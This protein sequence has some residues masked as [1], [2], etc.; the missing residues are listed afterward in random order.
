MWDFF[1]PLFLSKS[2]TS[3]EPAATWGIFWNLCISSVTFLPPE[4]QLTLCFHSFIAQPGTCPSRFHHGHPPSL[5]PPPSNRHGTWVSL[6]TLEGA[7]TGD[8]HVKHHCSPLVHI[9]KP[10]CSDWNYLHL[11]CLS[12]PTV[13]QQQQVWRI[14]WGLMTQKIKEINPKTSYDVVA[15]VQL[16][17]RPLYC[18]KSLY[19]HHHVYTVDFRN[20]SS[21]YHSAIPSE[22][23]TKDSLCN[24]HGNSRVCFPTLLTSANALLSHVFGKNL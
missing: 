3:N 8:S 1:S 13:S 4:L 24:Y 22:I 18:Y 21:Y 16:R 19:H 15:E 6:V 14:R 17:R 12:P 5:H 11:P 20:S 2:S 9:S 7:T 10:T 23:Q